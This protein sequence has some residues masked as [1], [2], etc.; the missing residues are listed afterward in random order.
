MARLHGQIG[1]FAFQRLH[2]GQ[3]IH[4]DRSF[5]L[6]G[7]LARLCVDLTSFNDLLCSLRVF[8]L[9][10]PVPKPVGLEAP[11]FSSRAVC[12]GEIS[13]TIPRCVSS[14]AISLPVHWLMGQP[15]FTGASQ[16]SLAM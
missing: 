8:F 5:P 12:R 14:S 7:P 2:P 15:V 9:G 10:Q 3:L 16:A 1:M 4:A 11:F 6:F 13:V